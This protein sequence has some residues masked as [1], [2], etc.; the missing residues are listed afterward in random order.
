MRD[1]RSA[2]D[3]LRKIMLDGFFPQDCLV[4]FFLISKLH[5]FD[6]NPCLWE[7]FV[8]EMLER[9]LW[10]YFLLSKAKTCVP[11]NIAQISKASWINK[12]TVICSP[13]VCKW[14]HMMLKKRW[15]LLSISWSQWLAVLFKFWDPWAPIKITLK[16]YIM[17]ENFTHMHIYNQ[18]TGPLP[19]VNLIINHRTYSNM[20]KIKDWEL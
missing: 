13:K 18:Q 3:F 19:F 10:V 4:S 6:I 9:Y 15:F 20:K 14:L 7:P 8:Y 5:F 1:T 12:H 17:C 11:P 2:E 16:Y